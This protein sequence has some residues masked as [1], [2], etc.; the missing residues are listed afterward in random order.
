M[1]YTHL[2]EKHNLKAPSIIA[3]MVYDIVKPKS[4][5]DIGC[6]LATFLR[7]FKNLGV[8]DVLGIDGHWVNRELLSKY[9]QLS[10]FQEADL[11]S[12]ISIPR[13]FDLAIS[14][15]VAE[16][17]SAGRADSFVEDLCALSDQILFSAAIP[18][19][20]GDNHINEQWV[21]YWKEK[22]EKRGYVML[23]IFREKMWNNPDILWWYRQNIFLFVKRDSALHERFKDKEG[24]VLNVVHPDLYHTW[25]NYRDRNAIKRYAKALYKAVAYKFG[26]I[27]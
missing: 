25:T 4:V 11:E 8:S 24:D 18:G 16:H 10:E 23:D 27:K 26:L 21:S 20:G 22:F 7:A 12:R 14:V 6:G 1:K 15:E 17:L 3:P 9:I 13:K 5:I 19:Q 2:E